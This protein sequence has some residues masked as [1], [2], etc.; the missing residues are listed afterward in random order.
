MII[1]GDRKMFAPLRRNDGRSPEA[2]VL[3]ILSE[4][5]AVASAAAIADE[6]LCTGMAVGTRGPVTKRIVECL[7]ELEEAGKV[8]RVPDGRY[9]AVRRSV[10]R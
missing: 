4:D 5:G 8:R 10:T 2:K 9:R 7:D 1:D 6:L 3:A